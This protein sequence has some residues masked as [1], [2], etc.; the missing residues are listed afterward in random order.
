MA[1]TLGNVNM[2]ARRGSRLNNRDDAA[3]ADDDDDDDMEIADG[4]TQ[5]AGAGPVY[6]EIKT[7]DEEDEVRLSQNDSS[8]EGLDAAAAEPASP[9]PSLPALGT[10][11][12]VWNAADPHM[13]NQAKQRLHTSVMPGGF[14]KCRER[15]R[16]K[17]VDIIQ[18]C[19][20]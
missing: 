15:E 10:A 12:V 4:S 11:A 1:M 16:R 5:P 2:N 18:G 19:L 7:E 6:V 17:V 8:F 20:K 9:E 13:V 14:A 3:A